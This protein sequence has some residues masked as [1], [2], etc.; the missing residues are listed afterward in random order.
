MAQA[1]NSYIALPK[2]YDYV[3]IYKNGE[4]TSFNDGVLLSLN[5]T[6]PNFTWKL[7]GA[8]DTASKFQVMEVGTIFDNTPA[9]RF[10]V[11][12]LAKEYAVGEHSNDD[13]YNLMTYDTTIAENK[14]GAYVRAHVL[15]VGEEFWVGY[16]GDISAQ[17]TLGTEYGVLATGEIG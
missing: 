11:N 4:T 17:Y 8:A 16:N 5:F 2:S 6:T 12:A 15:E 1:I 14:P 3:G 13:Y 10:R 9:V 7:P